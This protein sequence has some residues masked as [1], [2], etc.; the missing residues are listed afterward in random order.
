[1]QELRDENSE[2]EKLLCKLKA[3]KFWKETMQ[4]A[5][6]LTTLQ[7]VEK[8]RSPKKGYWL[9]KKG[10]RIKHVNHDNLKKKYF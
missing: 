5:Q 10:I 2:L 8:V 9:F 6:F 7:G 3:L 4:K 1:M